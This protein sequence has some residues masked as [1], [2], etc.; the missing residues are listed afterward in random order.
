NIEAT[1]QPNIGITAN[2]K[3]PIGYGQNIQPEK[4]N[5][6]GKAVNWLGE[7]YGDI[8]SYAPV[9]GNLL[10]KIEK[11]VT[12]R[13][14]RL[15]NTYQRQLVD[16]TALQNSINQNNIQGALTNNSGGDLGAL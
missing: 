13:G 9:V 3:M 11:P 6:I 10:N 8:M 15:D 4:K 12:A 14:N 1:T 16:E 5:T 2:T 7:N